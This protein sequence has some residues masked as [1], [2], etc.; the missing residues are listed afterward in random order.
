MNK[1]RLTSI[2][3]NLGY[4]RCRS[5]YLAGCLTRHEWIYIRDTWQRSEELRLNAVNN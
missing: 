4:H 3:V 1:K 2:L 5:L